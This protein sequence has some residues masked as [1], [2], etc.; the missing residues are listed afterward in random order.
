MQADA[1]VDKGR[2]HRQ[3]RH[4]TAGVKQPPRRRCGFIRRA[5]DVEVQRGQGAE[6]RIARARRHR[7]IAQRQMQ[8]TAST[9]MIAAC[10]PNS[11]SSQARP[12]AARPSSGSQRPRQKRCSRSS[13]PIRA[14]VHVPGSPPGRRGHHHAQMRDPLDHPRQQEWT[15]GQMQRLKRRHQRSKQERTDQRAP[16]AKGRHEQ[17][18][19]HTKDD[20]QHTDRIPSIIAAPTSGRA[21]QPV[22]GHRDLAV[23]RRRRPA[24]QISSTMTQFAP[25][26]AAA[27]RRPRR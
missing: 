11:A 2:Q 4:K 9:A 13:A 15:K 26:P 24:A 23:L 22:K 19:H 20:P 1:L 10:T 12:A 16:I 5:I 25:A 18:R 21:R 17:S 3:H 6:V 14:P 7:H 8:I 27:S